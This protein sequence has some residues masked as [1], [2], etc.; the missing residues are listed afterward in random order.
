M[1]AKIRIYNYL[2][3]NT[4]PHKKNQPPLEAD[5]FTQIINRCLIIGAC[6]QILQVSHP[7]GYY[8]LQEQT[9]PKRQAETRTQYLSQGN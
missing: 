4:T 1:T 8:S 3:Y 9:S 2:V 6:P 5:F 7:Y